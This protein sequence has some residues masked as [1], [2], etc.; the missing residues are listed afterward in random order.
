ML[1]NRGVMWICTIFLTFY[2]ECC[3]YSCVDQ[4]EFDNSV[5]SP[6]DLKMLP[7]IDLNY[8]INLLILENQA[9]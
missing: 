1:T 5:F 8:E 7:D 9:D 2:K 6:E 3:N 4:K